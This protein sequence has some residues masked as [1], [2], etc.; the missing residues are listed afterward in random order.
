MENLLYT[1][2]TSSFVATTVG[3]AINIWMEHRKSKHATSYDALAIA[4]AL[5]GYAITCADKI[6]DH[7]T[8]TTSDGFA[9]SLLGSVPDRPQLSVVAG[10]LRL[11]KE[12]LANRIM[13]FPQEVR[14]A[15][16][17]VAFWWD[18]VGDEDAMRQEA[19]IQVARIGLQSLDLAFDIRTEFRLPNR[20]L[21]FGEYN[22]RQLLKGVP[23]K[24][25]KD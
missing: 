25:S 5:E 14:Q 16:Q 21:V 13:V 3:A 2:I 1:V 17:S 12:Q 18:V 8:A 23:N 20:N 4:V 10:F 6:S 9:G 19:K 15:D 24:Q 7:D 22:I 11:R